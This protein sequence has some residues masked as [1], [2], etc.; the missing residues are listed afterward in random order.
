QAFAS[1]DSK[2]K[3]VDDRPPVDAKPR[4]KI[5][6]GRKVLREFT[7]RAF[8]RAVTKE[9]VERF[10]GLIELAH[11]NGDDYEK[12]L[13]LALEAVLVS[14]NFLSRMEREKE[15]ANPDAVHPV[16]EFELATRLSYFLWSTMPDDELLRLAEA[17]QLRSAGNLDKQVK[18]MLKDPKARALVENFA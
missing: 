5:E 3:L 6:T 2:Q 14:P 11:K 17:G 16:N 12:G 4:V 13:Q 8:R 15:P 7:R 18:R 10:V 9:E 1:P